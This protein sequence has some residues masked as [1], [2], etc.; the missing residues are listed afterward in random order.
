[1]VAGLLDQIRIR[2]SPK[3]RIAFITLDDNTAR[4]DVAVFA[5]DYAKYDHLLKKDEILIIKG[6]LGWDDFSGQVR[7]RA[8]EVWSFDQYLRQYGS[9][10]NLIIKPSGDSSS[11]VS[12]LQQILLPFKDGECSIYVKYQNNKFET[13]MK[14][15]EDWNISLDEQLLQRLNKVSEVLDATIKYKKQ[16]INA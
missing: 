11:F 4:I 3:G 2:N 16:E 13:G 8:T 10:L 14:L 1:L 9:Q 6:S 15:P 12:D 5:N 7:V